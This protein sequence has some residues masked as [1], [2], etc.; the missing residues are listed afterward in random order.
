[1]RHRQEMAGQRDQPEGREDGGQREQ[2][3]DARGHERAEGDHED[4]QRDREREEPAFARSS[5]YAV[6]TALT[7]LASPNSPM[8]KLGWARCSGGDAGRG[9]GRSCRPPCPCRRGSGTRRGPRA[10]PSRSG[11]RCRERA[12]SGRSGRRATFETRAT[13]SSIAALKAGSLASSEGLWIRTLSP[14]GCLKPASRILSMRPD[15]PGPVVFGSMLF[16]PTMPPSA[17]A[18][19]TKTSQPNVAV[20]Q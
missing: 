19:T 18:T 2:Q 1:M 12:A 4:D 16:V 6:S 15:S 20:F 10:R 7:A 11:R 14:A 8:K 13:T 5:A 17:K 3:R 9:R